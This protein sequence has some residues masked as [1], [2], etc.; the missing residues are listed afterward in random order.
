MKHRILIAAVG[1]LMLTGSGGAY[2]Q[3]QGVTDDEILIGTTVDL[4][5]PVASIGLPMKAGFEV[6]I[7]MVNEQGG[8]NGRKLRMVVEDNGYDPKRAILAVKKLIERDDVFAIVGMLGSSI[9]KV[10]TPIAAKENVPVLFP[11]APISA[12]YDPP[13]K[14]SFGF[15]AGY[16]I[17]MGAATKYAYETLGKRKF[18]LMYQDDDTGGQVKFGVERQLKEYDL[19]L[20]EATSFKRGATDFSAQFARMR[21]A[22]CDVVMLGTIVR[23]SAG[24]AIERQKI[25]WDVPLIAPQGAVSATMLQLA[26]GAAE[27]MYGF[28]PSVP[29]AIGKDSM[30]ALQE[31]LR[32][33]HEKEGTEKDP[34]D[35]FVLAYSA[36]MLFAE[37]ARNAGKDL[38]VDGLVA[39]LEQI[40]DFDTGVG[41]GAMTFTPEKRLG[42]S[43]IFALQVRDGKWQLLDEVE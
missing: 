1:L 38:T 4:T 26:D 29:I 15:I 43:K 14:L 8:I 36:I 35:F 20:V 22:D 30:P 23:E 31:A 11:G 27:G 17:Q 3:T 32:R 18:C 5:G 24:A 40:K 33:Y 28:T 42:S 19:S 39:G 13:Q 9:T 41:Q 7:D 6:G 34:D 10:T 25:G 21:A 16:E 12:V 37:G 2:G